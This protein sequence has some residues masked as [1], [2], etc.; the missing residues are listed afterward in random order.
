MGSLKVPQ[1]LDPDIL[2]FFEMGILFSFWVCVQ[3][4]LHWVFCFCW[5]RFCRLKT[6]TSAVKRIRSEINV[7]EPAV[8]SAKHDRLEAGEGCMISLLAVAVKINVSVFIFRLQSLLPSR[9]LIVFSHNFPVDLQRVT[10]SSCLN[11][12]QKTN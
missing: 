10:Q 8:L 2:S 6:D 12:I 1:Y 9:T 11:V 3:R 7:T 4:K 5:V